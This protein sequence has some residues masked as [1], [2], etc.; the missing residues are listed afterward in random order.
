MIYQVCDL[1]KK[2]LQK[3][4]FS[5]VFF[6]GPVKRKTTPSQKKERENYPALNIK[7]CIYLNLFHRNI[8]TKISQDNRLLYLYIFYKKCY[9][10]F[11]IKETG[12]MS[13][14]E[15]VKFVRVKL[16]LSQ[17]DLAR[18]LGVSFATINRWEN[19]SYNPSRLAKKA[20]EDFCEKKNIA[21]EE[22]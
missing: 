17:E 3:V 11:N 6:G 19:G 13:F 2:I 7:S 9:N 20:F 18:E 21:K 10:T 14:A 15:K 22:N 4:S 8:S 16:K 12:I 1:D 5:A